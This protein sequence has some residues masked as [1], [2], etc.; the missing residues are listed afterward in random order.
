MCVLA[1]VPAAFQYGLWDSTILNR[2]KRLELLLLSELS[3]Y[4]YWRASLAA[5]WRRGYDYL[6]FAGMLWVSLAVS[7]RVAWV[8]AVAAAF[9]GL[10][11]WAFSFAVGFRA[12]STGRQSSGLASLLT[13]GLPL[14]LVALVRAGWEPFAAFIPTAGCYLPLSTGVTESWAAGV[15]VTLAATVWLT[16]RGLSH[17]D[18][19]LRGWYDANEGRKTE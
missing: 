15:A 2:C 5:A 19:E 18:S 13:L 4:D 12:F 14:L 11:L 6:I 10:L 8:D 7:G 3:G 17:C 16:D 9:G 1:A